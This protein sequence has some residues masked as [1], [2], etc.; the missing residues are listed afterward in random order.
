MDSYVRYYD[1]MVKFIADHYDCK[2]K[3]PRDVR[4]V[5]NMSDGL[6]LQFNRIDWSCC[7]TNFCVWQIYSAYEGERHTYYFKTITQ[8][9]DNL[10][11]ARIKK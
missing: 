7:V 2:I 9:I 6:M 8:H 10:L 11:L 4:D 1:R 3:Y 5:N